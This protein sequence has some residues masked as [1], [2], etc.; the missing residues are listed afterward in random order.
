M[1]A[2]GQGASHLGVYQRFDIS[3]EGRWLAFQG[4]GKLEDDGYSGLVDASLNQ[5]DVVSLY[6]GLQRQL[7]LRQSCLLPP[8]AENLA[9]CQPC[10][11]TAPPLYEV[12]LSGVANPRSS[13]YIVNSRTPVSRGTH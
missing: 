13:Q 8:F 10:V 1:P 9:E 12:A 7:L 11:Q 6:I 4:N 2:G 5:A 3:N